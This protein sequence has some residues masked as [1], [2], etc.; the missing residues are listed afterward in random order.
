MIVHLFI[1]DGIS[2]FVHIHASCAGIKDVFID[3]TLLIYFRGGAMLH[4]TAFFED[5]YS[6]CIDELSDIV[7]DDDDRTPFFD[8]VD[9]G[10]DLLSS[11]SVEA[12]GG[13]V[14]ENDGRIL[15]KHPCD[16]NALLLSST[17]L[18]GLSLET[19]GQLHN[20]VVDIGLAGSLHHIL[21]GG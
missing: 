16:G 2:Y 4:H 5:I 8:G 3:P 17:E 13:F 15:D 21:M 10:L 7:R 19:V 11:D 6:V 20:L 18:E 1:G 12:C 14:K 9:A